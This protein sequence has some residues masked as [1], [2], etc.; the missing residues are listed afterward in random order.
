M[1][2]E[3]I[4]AFNNEP[5]FVKEVRLSPSTRIAKIL[6]WT[7][8]FKRKRRIELTDLA[9]AIA[10]KV[11]SLFSHMNIK[12]DSKEAI[13]QQIF[14]AMREN[15][16]L[17]IEALGYAIHNKQGQPPRWILESLEY[18]FT[19]EELAELTARVYGRLDV[20]SFFTITELI[21]GVKI[22]NI[23]EADPPGQTSEE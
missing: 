15:L 13:Q 18:E 1:T 14:I 8:L 5:E 16:P 4:E 12:E 9:T 7:G 10:Y 3:I 21:K 22:M 17:L 11:A 20:S 23:L 19:M 6:N 2:D